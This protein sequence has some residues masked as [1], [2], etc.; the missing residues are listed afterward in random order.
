MAKTLILTGDVNLMNVDDP[1][2]PFR[3]IVGELRAADVIF[4]NMECCLHLP[5]SRHSITRFCPE[6][7][8]ER[9]R[10]WFWGQ[11]EPV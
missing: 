10:P 11:K 5:A 1:A 7:M 2:E 3:K 6:V 9:K 4:G 8:H